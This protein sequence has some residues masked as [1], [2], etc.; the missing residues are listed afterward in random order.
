VREPQRLAAQRSDCV[1][2]DVASASAGVTAWRAKL[3][4]RC[5]LAAA[6]TIFAAQLALQKPDKATARLDF[7]SGFYRCAI[8]AATASHGGAFG[9]FYRLK[10]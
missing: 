10:I 1:L 2:R 9:Q 5:A 8:L 3:R 4:S 6:I 7:L